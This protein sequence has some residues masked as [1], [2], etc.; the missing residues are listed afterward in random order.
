MLRLGPVLRQVACR[1]SSHG[2]AQRGAVAVGSKASCT[3]SLVDLSPTSSSASTTPRADGGL[4]PVRQCRVGSARGILRGSW[5]GPGPARRSF[6]TS[7]ITLPADGEKPEKVVFVVGLNTGKFFGQDSAE[8]ALKLLERVADHDMEYQLLFGLTDRDLRQIEEDHDVGHSRKLT[9]SRDLEKNR[10]CEMIPVVQAGMVDKRP[11]RALDRDL[12]TTQSHVAW[13]LWRTPAEAFK[14][15][16]FMWR[17]H[18]LK[19]AERYRVLSSNFPISSKMYFD[20]RAELMAIRTVEQLAT[21]RSQGNAGTTVLV[22]NNELH[23][24]LTEQLERLLKEPQKIGTM[25]YSEELRNRA[26]DLAI[27]VPDLTSLIIFIYLGLPLLAFQQGYLF[28]EY[29]T[30]T[31]QDGRIDIDLLK[32]AHERE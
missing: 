13:R 25:D 29:L 22:V 20:E 14:L 30:T 7:A 15:Y 28:V 9:P 32:A 12:K 5:G 8:E 1:G 16:W 27:E 2:G 26:S 17:R 19:D 3:E 23:Y 10:N 4:R 24:V 11:R 6:A 31:T 18:K 21:D